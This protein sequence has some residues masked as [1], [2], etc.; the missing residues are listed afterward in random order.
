M[1]TW[2]YP[3]LANDAVART[4]PNPAQPYVE[5]WAGVSD[6][7]FHSATLPAQSEV[8]V[9]E[10]Y[11]PTVGMGGVTDANEN[12]LVNLS[13]EPSRAS[14]E[15]FSLAPAA[16][17]RVVLRR[18]DA[19]LFNETATPDPKNGNRISAAIPPASSGDVTATIATADGKELIAAVAATK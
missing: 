1:W 16:T 4:K 13:A 19:V 9:S 10:T 12:I 17:L 11:S 18:G 6:Q 2:G 3:S 5:L 14:L 15:F 7:F 8:S